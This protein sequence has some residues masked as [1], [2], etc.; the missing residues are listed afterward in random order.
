M[1]PSAASYTLSIISPKDCLLVFLALEASHSPY[2]ITKGS[3]SGI[4][5]RF[6]TKFTLAL[7]SGKSLFDAFA[8]TRYLLLPNDVDP[9]SLVRF[10]WLTELVRD[11]ASELHTILLK[12]KD[13][14][15]LTHPAA[16][17][18]WIAALYSTFSSDES[19]RSQNSA[20]TAWFDQCIAQPDVSKGV[21]AWKTVC[22]S[23]S[24]ANEAPLPVGKGG[25]NS[26]VVIAL[27]HH[28]RV[29]MPKEG[30][31]NI[32]ITSALPYVNNVPHLGNIIGS[33]LSAD[34][35]ARY[36]RARGYNTLYICG[37]DEYG[38]ATETKALEEGVSCQALCD[39]YNAIHNQVY[40]WFG[41]DF[42]FFG[43]TT[44]KQQTEIAQDIYNKL[45]KNDY[46][47][48]NT[49]TQLYCEKHQSFLADRYVEGTCPLCGYEDAR[50]DQCDSCQKLLN[51][52]ELKNPRCKLD[53]A[54]PV[55]RD[56]K[57]LF[58]NLTKLQ[59]L[60]Q[61][62]FDESSVQGKWSPNGISITDSWLK[63][64]LE[65]RC[66][67]R[68]L[69]WGT[70]V[71]ATYRKGYE[72]KVFYV[73]YDAPIGYLSITANYTPEWEKWWKNPANVKLYMFMGKDN[74]PFHTVIFPS[75]Q[76][77]TG[78]PYTLLH[79]V[80]TSE[81]LQYENGKFS[82]SRGVGVFGNNVMDSK[83]PVEVWRYYLLS[84]R[85][86]T[87]DSQFTWANFTAAN[88]NELL[89]NLGNFVNRIVKFIIAK[90]DSVIPAYSV[91]G[92]AETNLVQD[93]NGILAQYV[94]SLE[95][96]KLRHGLKLAMDISAR[97]NLYLQDNK[98]D[99]TLFANNRQRCDTVVGVA[100]NLVYLI[101]SLIYPY[102]P[103]TSESIM[104]QLNAPA[105]KITDTWDGCD[106]LSGHR[107][108]KAEYLFQRIDEA[109][110]TE[111]R[112]KYGGKQVKDDIPS[113]T[114][115]APS[116]APAAKKAAK[117]AKQSKP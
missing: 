86:E 74:V 101:S 109:K 106:I 47:I 112:N 65:P 110:E 114:A 32:L 7:P 62:F 55:V 30:S 14:F 38:T 60:N 115:A 24:G 93:V 13:D 89:A 113:A 117:E 79:H 43:R 94:E 16:Q 82:K 6:G 50:G 63:Q 11:H 29:V 23:S 4:H 58:V 35:Y 49:M 81:Y 22:G 25:V 104:R 21:A 8:A 18:V 77:G 72:N 98:I 17:A 12:N 42:D 37:T 46:I 56:S 70:P 53:G 36:C 71:P 88:N 41:I 51:P 45:E 96:V 99:N 10:T 97:G 67:T 19:V 26:E 92:V 87:G 2:K 84:N 54:T 76:I 48:E 80:S 40:K 3:A 83:V 57:H 116:A 33:V 1:A 39:K 100:A 52:I 78:D 34:V 111:L 15:L 66:I 20:V 9:P 44:T 105:R 5:K 108:G 28:S 27:D 102:M 64:G 59:P 31:R 91:A 95:A 73:W 61:K 103:T 107:I 68:D 85:P 69:K 75:C 90:Y